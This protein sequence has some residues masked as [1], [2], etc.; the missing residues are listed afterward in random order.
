[1]PALSVMKASSKIHSSWAGIRYLL[2][3]SKF[4]KLK[5]GVELSAI[6]GLDTARADLKPKIDHDCGFL[7]LLMV[8]N[9]CYKDF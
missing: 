4:P 6:P 7:I 1:M 5:R 3:I 2:S 9:L 8:E